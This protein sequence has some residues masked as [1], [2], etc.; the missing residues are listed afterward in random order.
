VIQEVGQ[1]AIIN[2]ALSR[3]PLRALA[4]LK[5]G[6]LLDVGCGRGDLGAAFIRR[7]WHV[8]GFD[9][10]A[11]ACAVAEARG[12]RV[13]LGT[14]E[15]VSYPDASFD[16]AIMNHT[17][18]HMVDPLADLARVKELLKPGGV[19]AISVPNFASWQRKVFGRHWF[20]LE[21]PRHR[22]HFTPQALT[23]AI[24]SAGFEVVAIQTTTDAAV[25]VASLQYLVA[26]RLIF[27]RGARA[28]SAYG[29]SALLSPF[30]R[31]ID[32]ALGQRAF[33]DAVARRPRR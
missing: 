4:A 6:L 19:I 11:A 22:T 26:G 12:L 30:N 7:G 15:T 29:F 9:P 8:D 28:W 2:R 27:D 23:R 5:P 18:E 3:M 13:Q 25:L 31:L 32:A 33:L 1:R 14:L 24:S 16:A 21:L 20:P 10:S 17:L